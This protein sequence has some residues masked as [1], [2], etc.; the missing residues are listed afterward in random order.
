[1]AG[2]NLKIPR[3][4][5]SAHASIRGY[6]YQVC[7]GVKRWLELEPRQVLLCE[8]DE[9]L[10]RLLL[11]KPGEPGKSI[12][13]QVKAL[14]GTVNIRDQVVLETLRN[15][16]LSYVARRQHGDHRRFIFTTTAERRP[17]RT[18]D[19]EVDVLDRWKSR[20]DRPKVIRAVRRMLLRSTETEKNQQTAEAVTGAVRWLDE[21][22][23]RWPG[24]IDSVDLELGA[25]R[26]EQV[27]NENRVLLLNKHSEVGTELAELFVDRL[28]ARVLEASSEPDP[29]ERVLD[30]K[31]LSRLIA[32]DLRDVAGWAQSRQGTRVRETFFAAVGID[33]VLLPGARPL[34]LAAAEMPP[35]RLLIAAHEVVPFHQQAREAELTQLANWCGKDAAISGCLITG[36]GGTGKTRLLIEWCKQLR[37]QGWHAGFVP[38]ELG[39]D[40][41][42]VLLRGHVPRLVVVDYAE[43]R[44]GQVETLLKRL[45]NR[46][47]RP[48]PKVRVVLLA[49]RE[50]DW[51]RQLSAG[52]AEIGDLV[53]TSP[54]PHNLA[55]LVPQPDERP[56]VYR[57]ALGV[58]ADALGR[59]VTKQET[60]S[61]FADPLFDR[62]LYLHAAALATVLSGRAVPASEVLSEVLAHERRF[63]Q[64]E[65]EDTF[66]TD[67]NA[68]D[69]LKE[70]MPRFMTAV[71]LLEGR[72]A[73]DSARKLICKVTRLVEGEHQLPEA[74]LRLV[75]RLYGRIE[76]LE[77]GVLGEQLVAETLDEQPDLLAPILTWAKA[78]ES[79]SNGARA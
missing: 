26:L 1:M 25:P 49:R 28:L 11:G 48:D 51:W 27:R 38:D 21:Q 23:D 59:D 30:G 17:Q 56:P 34:P 63:W 43:T 2:A 9:D 13:E 60:P 15:F 57:A 33:D 41:W 66:P 69:Q 5:R 77:P 70:A 7:L 14:S 42:S 45:A 37:S 61:D 58:F 76:A 46:L 71:T 32:E 64:R 6:L 19:L 16:M 39:G 4:E 36:E 68:V 55:P 12:S 20:S 72:L 31:A 74:L 40:W 54:A 10:D 35:G 78:Q 73:D 18:G 75:C 47:G 52:S 50:A 62:V 8:G 53:L 22:A 3:P 29:E 67:R 44:L 24:F 79:G 65:A